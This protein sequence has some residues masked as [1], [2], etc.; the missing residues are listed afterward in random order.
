MR[1]DKL[2]QVVM[3][4]VIASPARRRLLAMIAARAQIEYSREQA[5]LLGSVR[6]AGTVLSVIWLA[7]F[8]AAVRYFGPQILIFWAVIFAALLVARQMNI[9]PRI[10]AI[11]H[12]PSGQ[13]NEDER[14]MLVLIVVVSLAFTVMC[15]PFVVLSMAMLERTL[16]EQESDK[17]FIDDHWLTPDQV[18]QDHRYPMFLQ[19]DQIFSQLPLVPTPR[20]GEYRYVLSPEDH[21]LLEALVQA[22]EEQPILGA[23]ER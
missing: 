5:K 20:L 19:V 10:Q 6:V 15:L 23:S 11:V 18:V 21:S 7:V 13:R 22:F 12:K 1:D 16:I 3:Q 8:V 9:A 17:V 2:Q 14:S 4:C